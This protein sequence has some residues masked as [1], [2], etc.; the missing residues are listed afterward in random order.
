MV[1]DAPNS[2]WHPAMMPN[3]IAGVPQSPPH[4]TVPSPAQEQ[5]KADDT[6]TQPVTTAEENGAWFQD[7]GTGDDW[8][9]DTNADNAPPSATEATEQSAPAE[10]PEDARPDESS[11]ASKH[12]STM[13]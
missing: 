11:T 4:D 7:D 1:S 13:S 6:A 3:S 2:S 9:A 10:A 12:F 8:L 5:S